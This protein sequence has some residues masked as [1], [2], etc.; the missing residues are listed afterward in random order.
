MTNGGD[1]AIS[2][3][4]DGW[5][6]SLLCDSD[7]DSDRACWLGAAL[8]LALEVDVDVIV[9]ASED[10]TQESWLTRYPHTIELLRCKV[11]RS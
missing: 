9:A 6:G 3:S 11:E 7:G 10:M 1:R 2:S 8:A 4:Y 5:P